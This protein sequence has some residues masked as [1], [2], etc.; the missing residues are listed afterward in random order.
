MYNIKDHFERGMEHLIRQKT[1]ELDVSLW[2]AN[3]REAGQDQS[4]VM[5]VVVGWLGGRAW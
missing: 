3:G 5:Q 2:A 1:L 4:R